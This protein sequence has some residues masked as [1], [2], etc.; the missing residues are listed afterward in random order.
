MDIVLVLLAI[1]I[2]GNF[3]AFYKIWHLKMTVKHNIIN[4]SNLMQA[5]VSI[6][7][8]T[9][10][11][12]IERLKAEGIGGEWPDLPTEITVEDGKNGGTVH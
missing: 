5:G 8:S 1:A 11:S 7:M 4:L 9:S 10:F 12:I 6:S 3:L 2:A